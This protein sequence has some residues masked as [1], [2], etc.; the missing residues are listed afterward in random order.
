MAGARPAVHQRSETTNRGRAAMATFFDP[1]LAPD[2]GPTGADALCKHCPPHS[3]LR[4]LAGRPPNE[5]EIACFQPTRQMVAAAVR[6]EPFHLELPQRSSS[7][8]TLPG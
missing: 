2:S 6:A 4:E 5:V 3:R 8:A 7:R 1:G